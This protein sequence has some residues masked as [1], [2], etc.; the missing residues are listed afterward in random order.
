MSKDTFPSSF[1]VRC[2]HS[3]VECCKVRPIFE[4]FIPK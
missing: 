4:Q 2:Q 3:S 1:Q